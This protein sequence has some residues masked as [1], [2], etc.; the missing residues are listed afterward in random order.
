MSYTQNDTVNIQ[1]EVQKFNSELIDL[2]RRNKIGD[3]F[4]LYAY[5]LYITSDSD[6]DP[7]YKNLIT[8]LNGID[9]SIASFVLDSLKEEEW[10][11]IQCLAHKYDCSVYTETL[12]NN[13][14]SA[15][16]Y[17]YNTPISL[18]KLADAILNIQNNEKVADIGCGSGDYIINA[19]Q[20]HNKASFDGYE[21]NLTDSAIAKMR[22]KVLTENVNIHTY[23]V[24]ELKR[25]SSKFY[26]KDIK[27][28]K[29]FSN[30]PF[31]LQLRDL[32]SGIDFI[33][34]N[35]ELCPA[36]S[37]STSSDWV[38]NL[39]IT[40]LLADNGKAV[41]II[42]PGSTWNTID[43]PI[44]EYFVENGLIEAVIALPSKIFDYTGIPTSMIVLSKGNKKIRMIDATQLFEQ[45]RR[46][47][48][49]SDDNINTILSL[50]KED[51]EQ[52]K[53]I[54]NAEIK[55]NGYVINPTRYLTKTVNF[56]NAVK[57]ETVIRRIS[58]GASCT[59]S[60]LDEL[61]SVE[62][63]NFQYLMLSNI[64]QGQIDGE[65]PYLQ[66]VEPKLDK[67]CLKNHDLIL[68]KNGL[69]YKV[70]IAEIDDDKKI[71]AN[72]NLFIIEIDETK[73]NP[74]YI[75]AFLESQQG[76][77]ALKSITVGSVMPNIGV[78]ALKNMMI[79]L[80]A[81]EVQNKIA[82]NYLSAIDELKV[83]KLREKRLLDRLNHIYDN[84]VEE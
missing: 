63:T 72:G 24:F 81:M 23:N 84:E 61:A 74:Y 51:S 19:A 12:L 44:R 35:A 22:A 11:N 16:L 31:G 28:N 40:E 66:A 60:Q 15:A 83:L 21:I 77:A 10:K 56:E 64:K 50:L 39:L 58:R 38:F 82:T 2:Y 9:K 68:S 25:K 42:T 20:K 54:S 8:K 36:L 67:Y 45:G 13:S 7:T 53:K 78:E 46:L 29:I 5:L 80:P 71:L 52:S 6:K 70:A 69:P 27:Y 47:N 14:I 37:K 32:G 3:K 1:S 49:L 30:F 79:P 62:K 57:F 33:E 76:A 18:I 41:S 59:A 43:T 75:K 34:R 55:N 73:A 4:I 48:I 17:K 65:L 26:S